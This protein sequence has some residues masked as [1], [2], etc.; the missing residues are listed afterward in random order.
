MRQRGRSSLGQRGRVPYAWPMT[1]S[2][3]IIG[4]GYTGGRLAA[5][6]AAGGATVVATRRR[7]PEGVSEGSEAVPRPGAITTVALDLDGPT[8][9]A[10][11]LPALPEGSIA[12]ICSPPGD[13]P[14]AREARL[15][16][17]LAGASRIIYL[18]STGVYGPGRGQWIDE[19]WP[20][21][22]E[23]DSGMARVA[24]EAQLTRTA[25]EVGVPWTV[26]RPS[27]IYGPGRSLVARVRRGEA[28]VVG[29]GSAYIC[30]IHVDDLVAAI[31][32]AAERGLGG[33]INASDDD[34]SPYGQVL[35]EVAEKL[36]L[37]PA[38]R[39]DPETV[40]P[41]ARAMLL[42]NRKIAN[43]RLREELGMTLRYPSWRVA[44]DEELA[45]E[46]TS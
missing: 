21:A 46:A 17:A 15:V 23:S 44:V 33:M 34:P 5:Q 4:A 39:V 24:A 9:I 26:L 25:D 13:P 6:L 45:S 3:L 1:P 43:R 18:S 7:F 37:P 20:L 22:P 38:P 32:A 29:D 41:M 10:E 16:R 11:Q 28:R 14:G 12:V 31:V 42:A 2:W 27:G 8:P 36:G 35:D 30:R 40:S 19:A